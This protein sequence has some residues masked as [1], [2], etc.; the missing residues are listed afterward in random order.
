[1]IFFC[2]PPFLKLIEDTRHKY[3]LNHEAPNLIPPVFG[4][5]P[6]KIQ[7]A[8]IKAEP[9]L[10]FSVINTQYVEGWRNR[11]GRQTLFHHK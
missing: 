2:V 11:Q 1:M 3:Y 8:D 10:L 7:I 4:K 9:C 5:A 6:I